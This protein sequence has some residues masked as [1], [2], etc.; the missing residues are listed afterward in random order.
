MVPLEKS[1]ARS[2]IKELEAMCATRP[3]SLMV[4]DLAACY[5]T[6]DD[7]ARAL[8][9]ALMAWEKNR[10][11]GIGMNLAL[12]LKDLG[13]HDE[14]LKIMEEAFIIN[15]DDPYL[16]LGYAEGM[17]KAGHWKAAWPLYD[18]ARPTQQGAAL[19]LKLPAAV[20]EWS[21]GPLPPSATLLVINEG[22]IGDRI[23]YARYLPLLTRLGINWKFYPYAELFPFFERIFGRDKLIADGDH[24]NPTHWTTTFSLPAKL[25][26]GPTE[27]PTPLPLWATEDKV[28]K[29][30]F[31][32]D[33]PK[34]KIGIC[35]KAA[36]L[37]QGGRTVRSLSEGQAMRLV[38]MTAG[39]VNWVS[40]QFGERMPFPVAN[41]A[42]DDWQDTA[43]LI[44]NLDAVVTVDTGVMH[45]AGA[46]G[47]KMHVLLAG[48]SCWKFLR[49][50]KKLNLY[51]RATFHRNPDHGFETAINSVIESIRTDFKS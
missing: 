41:V 18:N 39:L 15:S 7:P 48:N 25:N 42:I 19:E 9:L 10:H 34:P 46:L 5:F 12:I 50:G 44:S 43:G 47:A 38:V 6:N 30:A 27:V 1:E 13:R 21:G 32:H 3:S 49:S 36:E 45:L 20:R 37:F 11:A 33:V 51:P 16:Q 2:R 40:L 14:A 4:A 29:Y 28:E 24:M 22:G 26:V 35:Y 23:S 8:P 31:L 17:L